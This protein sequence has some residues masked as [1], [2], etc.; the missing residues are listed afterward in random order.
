VNH[1]G[2]QVEDSSE[3]E[4]ITTRLKN[5]DLEV[6]DTGEATCC[7]SKSTKSWVTDPAGIAWEAYQTMADAEVFIKED[8]KDES[9][10]CESSETN[11]EKC[12][13]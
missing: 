10:C 4:E 1:L 8:E 12:C 3:L 2:I 7:Y 9:E 6:T 13:G 5:A 11:E